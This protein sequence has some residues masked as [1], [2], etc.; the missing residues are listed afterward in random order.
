M[1]WLTKELKISYAN[2]AYKDKFDRQKMFK[3]ARFPQVY[4]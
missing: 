1:R 4:L 3:E 2:Y